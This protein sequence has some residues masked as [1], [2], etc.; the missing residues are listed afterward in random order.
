MKHIG[1]LQILQESNCFN[2]VATTLADFEAFGLGLGAQVV[3]AFGEVDE[4]GG[5]LEGLAS[6]SEPAEPVGLVRAQAWPAG[7]LSRDTTQWF[8]NA[9]REQIAAAGPLDGVL[10]ALHGAL[11]GQGEPDVDGRL[12]EAVRAAVG[13]D[14]PIVAALDLHAYCTER[15]IDRADLLVAYHTSP[16]LD[17]RGTGVRAARALERLFAGASPACAQVRL[18]MISVAEAQN[19]FQPPM[20][21]VYERA[22][23]LEDAP[24]VLSAA[25][26]MTQSWL[27]VPGLGWSAMV[28]TNGAPDAA[29][30]LA[31]ELAGMCWQRRRALTVEHLSARESI[32]A[33]LACPGKPVVIADGADAT[34]SGAGGDSV[35]LL[36]EMLKRRI[37]D[38]AL[39]IMVDPEAVACARAAGRGGRFS[40][41]VGGKRDN[42][43]SQPLPVTGEVRDVRPARYMLTG[44]GATN[45]SVDMGMSAAVRTGDVT[46]L[47]VERPGPGSTPLM[48]RCVGLE[49]K[50]HKIVIVKSPAGFRAE[51][52]PFA[53]KIILSDCPG[54]ASPHYKRLPYTQINRPLCP[55]D[56]IEDRREAPWAK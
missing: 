11:V 46:L 22:R 16:H 33:A 50:D 42:V 52:E 4:I 17:R 23:E 41:A 36:E 9:L 19:S 48:Y 31:E 5:F 24:D 30:D 32:D 26:L 28:A 51:F 38:G 34:N 3:D 54:C 10:F 2:P 35:H 15:M 53:T 56:P 55:L 6:W 37:P 40:F 20:A 12:L 18:P 7:P 39:T 49:P 13:P 45:L 14:V 29:R 27:D 21:A 1:I 47:L 8:V 44:H 43:F 25:V